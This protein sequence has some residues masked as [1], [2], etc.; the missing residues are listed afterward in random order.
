MDNDVGVFELRPLEAGTGETGTAGVRPS[1]SVPWGRPVAPV[2][3][4][5]ARQAHAELVERLMAARW[6]RAGI[7]EGWFAHRFRSPVPATRDNAGPKR[8]S[9]RARVLSS[10]EG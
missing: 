2:P 9:K 6:R 7:G 4:P 10:D 5:E 3:I 8:T 1:P